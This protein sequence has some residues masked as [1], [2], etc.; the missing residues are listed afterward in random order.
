MKKVF[1]ISLLILCVSAQAQEVVSNVAYKDHTVRFTVITDGVLRMEWASDGRF[2]DNPSFVAVNRAYPAVDY[3]V[4]SSGSKVEIT[5]AK[6]KMTYN[7]GSG[8]FTADNLSVVSAKGMLPFSWKPGKK[9]QGNLKGTY[10]TL[11]AYEGDQYFYKEDLAE[12]EDLTMPIE[13]GLLATDGWTLVDDSQGLLFDRSDWPWVEQRPDTTVQDWYFMAYGHDYKAALKD[14][15]VF[16]GKVPLPPRYAFGYWWSRY[17]CYTDNELRDLVRN[18]RTHDIPLD[19]MVIDMDWHYTDAGRGG[20][21]GFTWNRGLFPDPDGLLDDLKQEGMQVTL[22]LHPA[23]GVAWFEEQY[24]EMA[25][26]MDANPNPAAKDTIKWAG[27][28][29]RFMSGWYNTVLRPLEKMGVDFW[30]L[31]WQQE[32]ND[33]KIPNLSNTWWLN[34]T[35]FSDM[36]RNRSTRPMLY[37]RWG[38]LG[39]HRYQIGFSGDAVTSWKSLDF[40]T[41]FNSTASNVLYG[42][43]S[44]DLGGHYGDT[45]NPELLTRWMQFGAVSPIMR[46]HATKSG[47]QDKEPWRFGKK[48]FEVLRSTVLQRY[49]L[50]PYI[51]RMARK[52]YEEGLSLCRPLYYDYPESSESYRFKNEYMFGDNMLVAPVTVPMEEGYATLA[53]WL[54]SGNDW[55]EWHT[56]TLLK[57]GQTVRRS[58]AIDEYPLYFKAGSIIPMYGKVKNLRKNDEPVELVVFPG[59]NGSFEMYE[60]NGNDKD[61]E[62]N[63]ATTALA[64]V[65]S[66]NELTVTIGARKGSYSGMPETRN[67]TLSVLASAIPETVLVN[68]RSVSYRYDGNELALVIDIPVTDCGREK[69]IQ[70]TYPAAAVDLTD[71]LVGK[72]RRIRKAVYEL[73]YR[74]AGAQFDDDMSRMESINREVTY[75]PERLTQCIERFRA[76]YD[77]LPGIL[78]K[79]MAWSWRGM[80][81]ISADD[82]QWFLDFVRYKE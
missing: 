35:T 5:T 12:G 37:H 15:T 24:R 20:W 18:F 56:G 65:R 31:D 82:R 36:Q 75:Y 45:I 17:W 69:V 30:W 59:G 42:Y 22:N 51:Y 34:Y 39:N 3:K 67:F 44:H 11:D 16:A 72:F 64:S 81:A 79:Q 61:Y 8:K 27:S 60:D 70:I 55:Y 14:F 66:G 32:L 26:W 25:E 46:T 80:A 7:K 63:F 54:P 19:V 71:G 38:G 68:G 29:K 78:D 47:K 76:S 62:R 13:D 50:T 40:Q 28:D 33:M 2:T 9:Q 41:W 4:K 53:V 52:T 43:W 10:R 58:F 49:R 77:N 23:D 57:G 6:M 48:Y 73:K 74:W 1:V 21:T